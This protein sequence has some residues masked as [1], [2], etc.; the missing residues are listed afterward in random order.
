MRTDSQ[1]E[2]APTW[3]CYGESPGV[4]DVE[5]SGLP[6]GVSPNILRGR[7]TVPTALTAPILGTDTSAHAAAELLSHR[8]PFSSAHSKT[9]YCRN[10]RSFCAANSAPDCPTELCAD[11]LSIN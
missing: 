8:P 9:L 3:R 7:S 11:S 5:V 10:A 6:L 2:G 4:R 1:S